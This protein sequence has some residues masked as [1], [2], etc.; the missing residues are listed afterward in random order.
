VIREPP[1]FFHRGPSPLARL[2]FFALLAIA[3]M[4]A[5]HRFGA[6]EA[7]RLSLSVLAA[8]LQSL[9]AAP[10]AAMSRV[11]DY[12]SSQDRL[13]REN[14]ELRAKVL[15]YAAAAQQSKLLAAEHERLLAMT[16][17]RS[18]YATDGQLAEVLSHGRNPFARKLVLDKGLTQGI[19]AGM[20][21]IDGEGVVGQVTAVGTFTSEVTLVT[22]KDQSV[23]VMLTRNGLRAVAVGSGK[24]GS[25]DVPFMPVSADVQN[26]DLFVT[27]GIDGTYPAGL[28]VAR[29]TAVE[30]NAAYMFAKITARPAAGVDNHRFVLILTATRPGLPPPPEARADDRRPARER[31]GAKGRRQ[32]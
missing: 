16:P 26:G 29:V 31:A 7:V 5:D 12:F 4:I 6:L 3:T 2:T 22:E 1:P 15:D 30:K 14:E 10:G 17:A 13:L 28:V 19:R 18:R 21:V 20:P 8:P 25:I 11:A 24:D 32:P 27:S 9:A 23:P